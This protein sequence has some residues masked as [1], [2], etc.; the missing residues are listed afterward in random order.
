MC[1]IGGVVANNSS[2]MAAGIDHPELQRLVLSRT[3]AQRY[4]RLDYAQSPAAICRAAS[5]KLMVSSEKP[6]LVPFPAGS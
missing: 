2:G 1:T 3:V 6:S 5:T 4:L